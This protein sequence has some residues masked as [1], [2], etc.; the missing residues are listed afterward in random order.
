MRMAHNAARNMTFFVAAFFVQWWAFAIY[1]VRALVDD[2]PQIL[3]QLVTIFN[4]L[5]G[6][7]NLG[8]YM[9]IRKHTHVSPQNPSAD[10]TGETP[11]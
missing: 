7:V 9:F 8:V 2:V 6:V 4:N 5:G 3:F 11:A 1:G 10:I